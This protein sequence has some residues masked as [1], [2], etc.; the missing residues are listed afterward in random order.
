MH[1]IVSLLIAHGCLFPFVSR[2]K[3]VEHTLDTMIGGLQ[4]TAR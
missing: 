3:L 2:K 1:G 4:S